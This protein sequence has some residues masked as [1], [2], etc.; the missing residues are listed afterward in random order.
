MMARLFAWLV[1]LPTGPQSRLEALRAYQ[2][3]VREEFKR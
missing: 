3:P 2:F 1:G